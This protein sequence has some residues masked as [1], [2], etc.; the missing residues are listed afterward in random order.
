MTDEP[1]IVETTIDAPLERVWKAYTS[2]EDITQWNFASDDWHCPGAKVDLRE[3][4]IFSA[5][6][7]SK[8]GKYGFDFEGTYTK[9][10]ENE[11][12]EYRFGERHAAV[13]FLPEGGKVTVRVSFDPETEHSLEQQRE[14]WQSILDNFARHAQQIAR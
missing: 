12:I 2:P 8:D 11:C 13:A 9:I 10:V 1:I 3:G 5:R 6:M 7:E 14:G 4:G